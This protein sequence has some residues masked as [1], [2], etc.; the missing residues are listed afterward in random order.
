[1]EISIQNLHNQLDSIPKSFYKQVNDFFESLKK[2]T[3]KTEI[4]LDS[5]QKKLLD[6]RLADAE[7][8]KKMK[9]VK[10]LVDFIDKL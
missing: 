2:Q 9:P 8:G 6:D 7:N 3:E 5:A 1:M 4:D 10:D